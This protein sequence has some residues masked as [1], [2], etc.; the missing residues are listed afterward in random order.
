M[1]IAS[2]RA[3]TAAFVLASLFAAPV[4]A[5]QTREP[6]L[7][8]PCRAVDYAFADEERDYYAFYAFDRNYGAD[9]P[10]CGAPQA[11]QEVAARR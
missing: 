7:A 8:Q 11:R 4:A 2:S 1:K 3:T 6:A 5:A 10:A 9:R